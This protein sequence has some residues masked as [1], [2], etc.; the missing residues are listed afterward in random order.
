MFAFQT[1]GRNLKRSLKPSL[2]FQRLY[3]YYIII[4]YESNH[5]NF[6]PNFCDTRHAVTH[7]TAELSNLSMPRAEAGSGSSSGFFLQSLL[8]LCNLSEPRRQ[9]KVLAYQ[10]LPLPVL[11]VVSGS[12]VV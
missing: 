1:A 12:R 3:M 9:N 4:Q 6:I 7:P 11:R 10:G 8:C 2:I 5:V